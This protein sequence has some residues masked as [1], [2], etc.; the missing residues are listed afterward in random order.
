MRSEVLNIAARNNVLLSPDALSMILSDPEP[1]A[2]INSVLS[3]ISESSV[4]INKSDIV[5]FLS[6]GVTKKD[7]GATAPKNK[8]QNDISIVPGTDITGESTCE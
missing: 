2:F 6:S 1:K 7:M 8:R 5:S 4:F 3:S